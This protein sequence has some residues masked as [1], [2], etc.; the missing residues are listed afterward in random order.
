MSSKETQ[1]DV[2]ENLLER[3]SNAKSE[4]ADLE[5]KIE[6]YKKLATKLLKQ[7]NTN[8]LVT[9]KYKLTRTELSRK[10]MC[11]ADVP[12]QIWEKYSHSCT[13]PVYYIKSQT[14]NNP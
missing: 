11:K 1:Q 9:K 7:N 6:K 12:D 4:I 2:I 8:E 3:W 10:T 14:K 5:I 13:Y